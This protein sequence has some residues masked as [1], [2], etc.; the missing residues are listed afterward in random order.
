MGTG[1]ERTTISEIQSS[2]KELCEKTGIDNVVNEI[3]K[4]ENGKFTY[5]MRNKIFLGKE[6]YFYRRYFRIVAIYE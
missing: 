3:I 1:E 2:F 4:I 6:E 5:K